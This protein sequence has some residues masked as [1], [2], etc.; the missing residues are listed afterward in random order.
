MDS[1]LTS[2]ASARPEDIVT[3]SRQSYAW[4]KSQMVNLRNPV[5][6]ARDIKNEKFRYT[7][8]FLIGGL[9]FFYY[10]PKLKDDLPYYD[11]FPLVIPIQRYND[12][13]LGLNLHYLPINYRIMFLNK[14]L[15]LA[16]YNDNDELKR[17][18][19]TYDIL[20]AS[21]RFKGFRPC[22]KRYLYPHIKSRILA[23]QPNEWDVALYLP[24]HQFKKENA[25]TVWT[26]SMDEIRNS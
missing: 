11:I 6:I 15:S 24:V 19:I 10:N 22:I 16:I 8:R 25:S 2:L 4:L 20:N 14:L 13:F 21:N 23:V 26:E 5:K 17:L 3:R 1:K 9:Y 12:G 18:R 7:S